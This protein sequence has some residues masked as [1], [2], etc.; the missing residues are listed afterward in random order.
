MVDRQKLKSLIKSN[1]KI[2]NS[3]IVG[4]ICVTSTFS[5]SNLALSVEIKNTHIYF[6]SAVLPM[7][8][9]TNEINAEV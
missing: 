1:G 6:D 8:N 2:G 9:F 7:R 3:Y 4:G 5:K